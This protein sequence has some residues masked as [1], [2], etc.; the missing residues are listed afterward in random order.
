[1]MNVNYKIDCLLVIFLTC[2]DGKILLIN[3]GNC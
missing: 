3:L 2:L 1:M